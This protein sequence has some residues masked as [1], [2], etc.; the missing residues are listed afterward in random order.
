MVEPLKWNG[1]SDL[2]SLREAEGL[3]HF[4][5]RESGYQAGAAVEFL[6]F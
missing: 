3:I 6:P 5:V 4:P 1:S 2:L